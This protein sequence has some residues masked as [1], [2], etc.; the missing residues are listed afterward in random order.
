MSMAEGQTQSRPA[1]TEEIVRFLD[2]YDA[3]LARNFRAGYAVDF[4]SIPIFIDFPVL[5]LVGVAVDGD[6]THIR[7]GGGFD[8]LAAVDWSAMTIEL[9]GDVWWARLLAR[10][11]PLLPTFYPIDLI[12]TDERAALQFSMHFV[13]G[14][15]FRLLAPAQSNLF[16]F[17]VERA[18]FNDIAALVP[19]LE[20]PGIEAWPQVMDDGNTRTVTFAQPEHEVVLTYSYDADAYEWGRDS[21]SLESVTIDGVRT[22][23]IW[24]EPFVNVPGIRGF[25]L[26]DMLQIDSALLGSAPE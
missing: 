3:L 9:L 2:D 6:T 12:I 26:P 1:T 17:E 5:R 4:Y 19:R 14:A 15:I 20:M 21:W 24:F 22:S 7:I 13:V 10:V 23:F 25:R 18:L 16:Y 8:L 11:M